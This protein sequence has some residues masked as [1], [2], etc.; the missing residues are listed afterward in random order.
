MNDPPTALVG[1][2]TGARQSR[3]R[4]GMNDPPTALVDSGRARG[5]PDLGWYERSANC[6]WWDSG[7]KCPNAAVPATRPPQ[8]MYQARQNLTRTSSDCCVLRGSDIEL[9]YL[10]TSRGLHSDL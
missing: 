5:S 3:L 2:G 8:P 6:I 7:E 10:L 9:S 1:F 4:L